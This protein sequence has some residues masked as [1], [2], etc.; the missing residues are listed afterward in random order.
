MHKLAT[1]PI[2]IDCFETDDFSVENVT[3]PFSKRIFVEEYITELE[4]LRQKFAKTKDLRDWKELIRWLPS[5][6]LQTR[7]WTANYEVL[8]NIYFQR[9]NHK[10][11]EWRTFCKWIEKLPYAKELII[12]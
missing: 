12:V 2:T 6:W 4:Q 5:S 7:T 11:V 1:T 10:L 8:R 3:D 9:K